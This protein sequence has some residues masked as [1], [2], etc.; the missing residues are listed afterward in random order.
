MFFREQGPIYSQA[1]KACNCSDNVAK[2]AYEKGW[3]GLLWARPIFDVLKEEAEAV[4]A[5]RQKLQEEQLQAEEEQRIAARKDALDARKQEAAGAKVSRGNAIRLGINVTKLL[6]SMEKLVEEVG[7]RVA[8]SD[9]LEAI[10]LPELRKLLQLVPQ[11][12]KD[13]QSCMQ[14]ALQIERVVTGEPIAVLGV[15]LDTMTP[16][17]MVT[18]LSNIQRTLARAKELPDGTESDDAYERSESTEDEFHEQTQ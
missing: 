2:A 6:V 15:R 5:H 12:V 9:E 14:M 13:A 18:Q 4:R 17:Q 3:R 10:P 8:D 7:R 16:E 11:A 1:A